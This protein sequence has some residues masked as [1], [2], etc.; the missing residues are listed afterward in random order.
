MLSDRENHRLAEIE[1]YLRIN[2]PRF[3]AKW[4]R[5][6]KRHAGVWRR[7]TRWLFHA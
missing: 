1:L 6:T 3:L 7:F 2:E 5:M 4:D